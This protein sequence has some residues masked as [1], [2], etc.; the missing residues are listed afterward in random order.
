MRIHRALFLLIVLLAGGLLRAAPLDDPSLREL[1]QAAPSA[2]DYPGADAVWLRRDFEITV[3]KAGA[4]A[5]HERRLIKALTEQGLSL[6]QWEIPY[7]KDLERL[8]VREARTIINGQ[9]FPVNPMQVADSAVYPGVAWYDALM[10]RRFPLPAAVV[11]AVFQVDTVFRRPQPRMPGD[12]SFRLSLQHTHPILHGQY[13]LRVPL[14]QRLVIRFTGSTPPPAVQEREENGLR[15]YRWSIA[16]VSALRVTEPLTPPAADLIASARITNLTG[17]TPVVDWYRKLTEGKDAITENIRRVAEERTQGCATPDAK[18]AA[19]HTAVRELP[20]VA[21]EMGNLS[22][23]PHA[24]DEVLRQN[25]GDCK[26]K[27]TLLRALLRA[28]GVESDYVLVRTTDK[29]ALDRELYGPA[30]FNH[31]I[32]AVKAPDGDRYL[33][34]T[35]AEVPTGMLPSHVEGAAGLVIRDQGELVTLP[36]SSAADNRTDV[37]VTVDVNNDGSARGRM[38]MTF[39]GQAAILQ[40]GMLARVPRDRYRESLEPSLAPRLGVDV[41]IETVEVAN[42]RTPDQPLTITAD[43]SS[44]AFLQQAGAQLSGYLPGFMY[45]QNRF[46]TA[47]T[48]AV[49]FLQRIE[50]SLRLET[51]INLPECFVVEYLPESARYD[52]PVGRYADAAVVDGRTVRFTCDL[53]TTRGFFPADT[54]PEFRKWS[55]ILAMEKRNQLQFYVKKK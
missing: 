13:I 12:I 31:V 19:L 49:P 2:A 46:R 16:R 35:V 17:W 30:D 32:L 11:G 29:G 54:L 47:T 27:A 28:V 1:L 37:R 25:F 14:D 50:S 8:E 39:T 45:Q 33:D 6:A 9:V 4:L 51:T 44:P 53:A 55:A 22:D 52:G 38:V 7:D 10:L 26:D 20:Y 18:I 41:T 42:L 36:V 23:V 21:L 5:V 43:F 48:R 3:D 24:A 34:A 15:V 40:R